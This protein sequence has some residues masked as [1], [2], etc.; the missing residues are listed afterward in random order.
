VAQTLIHQPEI[1]QYFRLKRARA[2]GIALSD[3]HALLCRAVE[4]AYDSQTTPVE[5]QVPSSAEVVRQIDQTLRNP[6]EDGLRAVL[7]QS[8]ELANQMTRSL[9]RNKVVSIDD[10]GNRLTRILHDVRR[11]LAD[12]AII[13]SDITSGDSQL[14]STLLPVAAVAPLLSLKRAAQQTQPSA[15]L[16][17]IVA[18]GGA[19][20]A[21][22]FPSSS[23]HRLSEASAFPSK[24]QSSRQ[25]QTVL[26]TI[27]P[28]LCR[29]EVGDILRVGNF[30]TEITGVSSVG[31]TVSDAAPEG[32]VTITSAAKNLMIEAVKEVYPL[33]ALLRADIP[34]P[35]E[36]AS[37]SSRGDA[38]RLMQR[39]AAAAAQV[40]TV[41]TNT[42]R[43]LNAFGVPVP[44]E[45]T[46]LQTI[47]SIPTE[48]APSLAEVS[49]RLVLD[50]DREGFDK[51]AEL[52]RRGRFAIFAETVFTSA[53]RAFDLDAQ[54]SELLQYARG[55]E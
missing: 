10:A 42:A 54:T 15:A 50:L 17:G 45:T 39:L 51:A 26:L 49:R 16:A 33:K 52:L 55:A 29:V 28:L 8:G 1:L 27:N 44:T 2:L 24:F 19:I 43:C 11:R 12:V 40:S 41:T 48:V 47:L 35:E 30:L 31:V 34:T 25:G 3:L 22:S 20:R 53:V 6:T 4:A 32:P 36:A 5:V 9:V 14:H 18:S 7:R 21:L 46:L 37:I 13:V 23:S 38:A